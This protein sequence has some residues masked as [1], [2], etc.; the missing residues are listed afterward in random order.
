M[1]QEADGGDIDVKVTETPK[2][3]ATV[4]ESTVQEQGKQV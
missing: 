1:Q 2:T 3:P 4:T